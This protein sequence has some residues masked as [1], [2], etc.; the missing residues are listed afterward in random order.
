MQVPHLVQEVEA[1]RLCL[2]GVARRPGSAVVCGWYP[3]WVSSACAVP[4]VRTAVITSKQ[5]GDPPGASGTLTCSL[6]A[7]SYQQRG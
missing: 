2:A 4:L 7:F 3:C 1:E 5:R 6:V